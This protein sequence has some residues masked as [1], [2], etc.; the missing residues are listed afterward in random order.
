MEEKE[1]K[2]DDLSEVIRQAT[3]L[4]EDQKKTIESQQAEIEELRKNN[5]EKQKEAEE[6]EKQKEAEEVESVSDML[7]DF[8][9]N[10]TELLQGYNRNNPTDNNTDTSFED[11]QMNMLKRRF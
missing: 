6:V 1:E 5:V 2:K 4:I 7:A 9:K 10:I 3:E 11:S 8:K